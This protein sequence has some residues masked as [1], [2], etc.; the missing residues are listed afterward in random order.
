M[1]LHWLPYFYNIFQAVRRQ[2]ESKYWWDE[3]LSWHSSFWCLSKLERGN[4]FRQKVHSVGSSLTAF[5]TARFLQHRFLLI[6]HLHTHKS[7]QRSAHD[8]VWNTQTWGKN[9]I[10]HTHH[11][12]RRCY[13]VVGN[14]IMVFWTY[15]LKLSL[16]III[17]QTLCY[18]KQFFKK[19]YQTRY[20]MQ[21]HSGKSVKGISDLGRLFT[22][23]SN[24][25]MWRYYVTLVYLQFGHV[26]CSSFRRE[27]ASRWIKQPAHIKCP[28]VHYG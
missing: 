26:A 28:L 22:V 9:V 25:I 10:H 8:N 4:C 6:S 1:V 7:F 5:S 14:V 27:S 23:F 16:I 15:K 24:I 19:S 11:L 12:M 17:S 21:Q 18:L 2:K 20:F 13:A 3:Y